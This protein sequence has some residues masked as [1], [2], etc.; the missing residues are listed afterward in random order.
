MHSSVEKIHMKVA[1][2]STPCA[3]FIGTDSLD[4]RACLALQSHKQPEPGPSLAYAVVHGLAA[5]VALPGSVVGCV[6]NLNALGGSQK[7]EHEP[8]LICKAVEE[9]FP[10]SIR[11]G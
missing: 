2:K 11:A 1:N 6:G 3:S 4:G 10:D 8:P 9:L 5:K 7:I